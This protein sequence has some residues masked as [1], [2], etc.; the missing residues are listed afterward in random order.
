MP[1][2]VKRREQRKKE[3]KPFLKKLAKEQH[4]FSTHGQ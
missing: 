3:M 2:A 4:R 1:T